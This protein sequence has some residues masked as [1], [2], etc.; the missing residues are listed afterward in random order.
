MINDEGNYYIGEWYKNRPHGYGE[1]YNSQRN[2]IY[3]GKWKKGV[4]Q[5]VGEEYYPDGVTFKG[6]YKDGLKNGKGKYIF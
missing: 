1:Y 6:T 3:K 2:W 5:G 4:K